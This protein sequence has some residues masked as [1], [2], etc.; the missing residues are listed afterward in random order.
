VAKAA[1]HNPEHSAIPAPQPKGMTW[2]A[3][4]LLLFITW[5]AGLG[6]AA[7]SNP[8]LNGIPVRRVPPEL[9]AEPKE[10]LERLPMTWL[11]QPPPA[12]YKVAAGDVLGVW[13]EGVLGEVGKPPPVIERREQTSSTDSGSSTQDTVAMGYPIPV[14]SDGTITLPQVPPIKVEGMTLEQAEQA[15]RKAYTETKKIIQPK[16]PL[17]IVVTLMRPRTFHVLVIR[18]DGTSGG[19]PLSAAGGGATG[20]RSIG[21]M[22]SL[23]GGA[24]GARKGTGH[25]LDLPAYQNDVLNA[26]AR[27]GGLPGTDAADEIIIERGAFQGEQGRQGLVDS[28]LACPGSDPLAMAPGTQRIR[29]PLRYRPGQPPPVRPEQIILQTGDIV[30][31]ESRESEVFYAAG[32]LPSGEYPLPRDADLDV[33]NAVLR[34]GGPL[35]ISGINTANIAGTFVIPGLGLPRPT[36]VNIVRPTPCGKQVV[37]R[38]DLD[39]ALRDPRERILIQPKDLLVLQECPQEA[40]GRYLYEIL[41]FPFHYVLWNGPRGF[42][43]IGYSLGYT[44]AAPAYP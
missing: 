40:F 39:R 18:Q 35:L 33:V 41:N 5:A 19:Q 12:A 21:F 11:R 14:R 44:G 37:I 24:R 31:I 30:F 6:C 25:T 34:I 23:G 2:L 7:L 17:S 43:S 8:V 26:L 1:Q 29:I 3:A 28:L 42:G 36:L 10:G 4:P 9:L 20:A 15:V 13:V 16:A 27:T 32:L 38:V 22:L